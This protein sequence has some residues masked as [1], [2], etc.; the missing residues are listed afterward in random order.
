MDNFEYLTRDASILGPHHLQE[1]VSNWSEFD[2]QAT[3]V[4]YFILCLQTIKF[5]LFL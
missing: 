5:I 4:D 1:F 3:Y 2:P